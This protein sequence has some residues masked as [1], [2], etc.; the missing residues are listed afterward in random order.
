MKTWNT[1]I[2]WKIPY[3]LIGFYNKDSFPASDFNEA[4]NRAE[5]LNK[6]NLEM[7]YHTVWSNECIE[8]WFLLHFTYY[9]ANNHRSE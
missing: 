2:I 4:V 8:F 9:T 6:E 5:Q 1:L 3:S 7:Q